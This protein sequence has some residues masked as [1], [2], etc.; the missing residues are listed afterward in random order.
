[1][2]EVVINNNL[3]ACYL[4]LN[5]CSGTFN[6]TTINTGYRGVDEITRKLNGSHFTNNMH[7][8]TPIRLQDY[9]GVSLNAVNGTWFWVDRPML[10]VIHLSSC[11]CESGLII[12]S[13]TCC[14]RKT[15]QQRD[16]DGTMMEH[17]IPLTITPAPVSLS[18]LP[19]HFFKTGQVEHAGN[20]SH[21]PACPAWW[22]LKKLLAG[23]KVLE[24]EQSLG[25]G[26]W[27]RI[28]ISLQ[29]FYHKCLFVAV[30]LENVVSHCYFSNPLIIHSQ[31]ARR[32]MGHM[33]KLLGGQQAGEGG[34]QVWGIPT[35][36]IPLPATWS[37]CFT[38]LMGGL[39]LCIPKKVVCCL[40]WLC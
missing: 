9:L 2:R 29:S 23:K 14:E 36:L 37:S 22:I 17:L 27:D 8:N 12:S 32:G 10:A 15:M 33:V 24:E 18:S 39:A 11:T 30:M 38:S 5:Q 4:A 1:M 31:Q 6:H 28:P 35:N 21:L 16:R 3:S 13:L 20:G 40:S 25:R 7:A 26:N 34:G 19:G